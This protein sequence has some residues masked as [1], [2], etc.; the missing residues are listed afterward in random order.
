MIFSDLVTDRAIAVP[1]VARDLAGVLQELMGRLDPGIGL[2]EEAGRE[3]AR[4]LASGKRGEI[5]RVND[6]VVL[7]LGRAEEARGVVAA[8][9]VSPEPLSLGDESDE[10][11]QARA[12]VLLLTP[13]RVASLREEFV[14]ALVRALRDEERTRHLLEARSPQDVRGLSELMETELRELPL[15]GDALTPLRYRIYPDTPL[16]EV[17]GLMVRRELHAVPVVGENLQV[18]G[19]ISVGDALAHLLPGRRKQDGAEPAGRS[20]DAGTLTARDVM[21]R[22]V[23]CVSEDQS[24]LEAANLMVNRDVDQLPVVREGELIGFL[25]RYAV[26]RRL[27]GT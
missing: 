27:F 21:T 16:E 7:V 23:M 8:V 3:L 14:P 10:R 9:A 11:G 22:T 13:R 6:A 26:L 17:V 5:V 24:L 20:T 4:D 12:V 15:V 19:I 2:D 18:L 1:P 25:T